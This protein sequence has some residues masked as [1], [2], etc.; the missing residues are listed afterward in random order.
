MMPSDAPK[1]SLKHVL[2]EVLIDSL[3]GSSKINI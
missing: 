2:S 1:I 3:Y